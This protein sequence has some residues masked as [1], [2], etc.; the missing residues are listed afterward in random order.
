MDDTTTTT[1]PKGTKYLSKEDIRG[2]TVED[3]REHFKDPR[4][5]W[6]T[7][8]LF[9]ETCEDPKKYPPI[10]SLADEDT[11]SCVSLKRLYLSIEDVTEY[12]FA[13]ACL[14]GWDHWVRITESYRLKNHVEEWRS[15]LKM[16]LRAKYIR[17]VKEEAEHG[18]GPNALAAR[19]Y[20]LE[21]TTGMEKATKRGRPSKVEKDN[22]LR[23]DAK[24]S[25][26][27]RADAAR[28]G[29]KIVK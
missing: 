29:L 6:R 4:G 28:L 2:M 9:E 12:D 10:F 17:L 24:D 22:F 21:N 13:K 26:D 1:A 18:D 11:S 25:E 20:L 7:A 15:L 19:K 3:L 5:L 27:I 23:E 16:Q 14:G 8:S